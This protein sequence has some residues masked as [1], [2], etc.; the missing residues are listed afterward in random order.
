MKKHFYFLFL[1]FLFTS[2]V[3]AKELYTYTDW[4][5]YYPTGVEE[6]RIETEDRYYWYKEND[7]GSRDTTSELLPSMD[8]YTKIEESKKTF[9]RVNNGP[10]IIIDLNG[11]LLYEANSCIKRMC[12]YYHVNEYVPNSNEAMV[13]DNPKTGDNIIIYLVLFILSIIIMRKNNLVLSN[14]FKSSN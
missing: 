7:D 13:S 11:N 8:G 1:I 10:I 9:Y 3:N 4:F 5:D 2:R 6:Y 12:H 14:R